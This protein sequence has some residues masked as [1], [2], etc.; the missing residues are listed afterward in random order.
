MHYL[1][2]LFASVPFDVERFISAVG[3]PGAVLA[4]LGWFLLRAWREFS[5]LARAWLESQLENDHVH[6]QAVQILTARY[7]ELQLGHTCTHRALVHAARAIEAAA[8][9]ESRVDVRRH[10]DAAIDELTPVGEW[11]VANSE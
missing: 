2:S 3:V 10:S 4:A 11:R 8:A 7:D 6:R 1:G 9:P 5:P